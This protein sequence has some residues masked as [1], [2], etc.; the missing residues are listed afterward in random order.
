MDVTTVSLK[1]K[2][3]NSSPTVQP[4][5]IDALSQCVL[6]AC[7]DYAFGDAEYIWINKDNMIIAEAYISSSDSSF[8]TC[9][10]GS[11]ILN[12]GRKEPSWS[13]GYDYDDS[14][15]IRYDGKTAV[16]LTTI[17][18]ELKVYRNDSG[19]Q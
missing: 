6:S 14:L 16:E 11:W 13:P 17:Y 3:M 19:N 1:L 18:S 8:W 7:K 10:P 4:E 5:I 9:P 2:P 12:D 15:T